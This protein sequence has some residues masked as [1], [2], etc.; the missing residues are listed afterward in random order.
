MPGHCT[1]GDRGAS[2]PPTRLARIN[3]LG[4]CVDGRQDR[5]RFLL[6]RLKER[7]SGSAPLMHR[8]CDLAVLHVPADG[9]FIGLEISGIP[10]GPL[11]SSDTWALGV[12]RIEYALGEGPSFEVAAT[13]SHV[14]ASSM[15]SPDTERWPNFARAAAAENV[16]AIFCFP[17]Q[18]GGARLGALSLLRQAPEELQDEQ[19]LNCLAISDLATNALLYAQAGLGDT[20][21][22][23]LL[24]ASDADRL[25]IHQA[26]GMVAAMLDCSIE[27]AI[28]RLRARAFAE[29]MS[30]F[31]LATLV[32]NRDMIFEEL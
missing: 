20:Q 6:D 15:D 7:E 31:D 21:F 10:D 14:E 13:G 29:G 9:A 30:L 23:D 1:V 27:D 16:G 25:R 18:L 17:L 24:L 28:A 26:T 8:L 5:R 11:A 3:R 22:E 19:Y 12:A 4:L 2:T 32:I